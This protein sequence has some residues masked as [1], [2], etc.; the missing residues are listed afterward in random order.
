MAK[1]KIQKKQT[2]QD[3]Y[4]FY[5]DPKGSE[6]DL[7]QGHQVWLEYKFV[8]AESSTEEVKLDRYTVYQRTQGH[9]LTGRYQI[10]DAKGYKH[11]N[12]DRS[13]K[14]WERQDLLPLYKKDGKKLMED[15]NVDATHLP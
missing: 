15:I 14:E 8:H 3:A 4:G 13:H 12:S 11:E 5:Y 10:V 2:L 7:E 9:G 1:Q 6:D